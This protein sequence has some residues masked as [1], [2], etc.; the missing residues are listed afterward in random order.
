MAYAFA[1][2]PLHA[3]I[4]NAVEKQFLINFDFVIFKGPWDAG[5][6]EN[7]NSVK[8][9]GF[10]EDG[11][12]RLR[13]VPIIRRK[14]KEI[15]D[16]FPEKAKEEFWYPD[17]NH[18]INKFISLHAK[19]HAHYSFPDGLADFGRMS[20][21]SDIRNYA[22]SN[23][24]FDGFFKKNIKPTFVNLEHL[25]DGGMATKD[26]IKINFIKDAFLRISDRVEGYRLGS[27]DL[28]F[29]AQPLVEMNLIDVD[30]EIR[31][32]IRG[33]RNSIERNKISGRVYLK[34]HPAQKSEINELRIES[35]RKNFGPIEVIPFDFPIECYVLAAPENIVCASFYSTALFNIKKMSPKVKCEA[36]FDAI[37]FR[38][39]YFLLSNKFSMAGIMIPEA[40]DV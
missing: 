22:I 37:F 8:I 27:N 15:L 19:T 18:Y 4:I 26:T 35:L 2:S 12:L 36:Y 6:I 11:R 17:S 16:K 3:I 1:A 21:K 39:Q 5:I 38:R 28:L 33:I 30:N 7:K 20:V 14:I 23:V 9:N 13:S 10:D 31:L 34:L 24:L 40:L 25:V 29:I 32:T